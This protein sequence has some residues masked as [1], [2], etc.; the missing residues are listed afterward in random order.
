MK[1]NDKSAMTLKEAR[2]FFFAYRG[3][4]FFIQREEPK[5]MQSFMK[6]VSWRHLVL[7]AWRKEILDSLYDGLVVE[8]K[9]EGAYINI[10]DYF[11]TLRSLKLNIKF[12]SRSDVD[13]ISLYVRNCNMYIHLNKDNTGGKVNGKRKNDR[14][15]RR[16]TTH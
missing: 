14:K 11:S 15:L 1:S 13:N 3:N 10:D 2:S 12:K 5:Q 8:K 6:A 4:L 7:H 16:H 9:N